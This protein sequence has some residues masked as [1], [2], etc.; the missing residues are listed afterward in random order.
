M[1]Y[2]DQPAT[3]ALKRE[4]I[5]GFIGYDERADELVGDTIRKNGVVHGNSRANHNT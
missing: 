5:T 2:I 3:M 4:I 1:W